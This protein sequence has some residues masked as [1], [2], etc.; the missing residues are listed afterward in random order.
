MT[1][2]RE[3]LSRQVLVP[4][5][6]Q[7]PDYLSSA[8]IP[9]PESSEGGD[10]LPGEWVVYG[11]AVWPTRPPTRQDEPWFSTVGAGDVNHRRL[12][13]ARSAP[14][15]KAMVGNEVVS[16]AA[17]GK[18]RTKE[19]PQQTGRFFWFWRASVAGAP[20]LLEYRARH[21]PAAG[22]LDAVGGSPG[23]DRFEVD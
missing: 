8:S 14:W 21:T 3:V 1:S 9:A 10:Q 19:P 23:T 7:W 2:A 13:D 18:Q 15:S 6:E 17:A 11:A 5:T 22:K 4:S 20:V 12:T 16:S